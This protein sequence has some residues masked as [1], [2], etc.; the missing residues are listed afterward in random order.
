[1]VQHTVSTNSPRVLH[2]SSSYKVV[3][4]LK[5]K[6]VTKDENALATNLPPESAK[7]LEKKNSKEEHKLNRDRGVTYL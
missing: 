6:I 2:G 5:L 4:S 3:N 1:M 7:F